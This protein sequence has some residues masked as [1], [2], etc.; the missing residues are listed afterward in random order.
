MNR[1]AV[2]HCGLDNRGHRH[3]RMKTHVAIRHCRQHAALFPRIVVIT[4]VKFGREVWR[5]GLQ[6]RCWCMIA[7]KVRADRRS[8]LTTL[9]HPAL[10]S[11][12]PRLRG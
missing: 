3:W 4:P 10:V 1:Y 11:P 12:V 2:Y 6:Q 9:S 5:N 7:A 8:F